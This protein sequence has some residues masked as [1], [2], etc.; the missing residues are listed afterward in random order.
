MFSLTDSHME[1][2]KVSANSLF[3]PFL[4]GWIET[5]CA[6]HTFGLVAVNTSTTAFALAAFSNLRTRQ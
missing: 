6:L 2:N 1:L 3:T 4:P 5:V